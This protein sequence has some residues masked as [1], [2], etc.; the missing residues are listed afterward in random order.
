MFKKLED[1][2]EAT[3]N[4]YWS[5]ENPAILGRGSFGNVQIWFH[6][7]KG[8]L[9]AAKSFKAD[10][11]FRYE[12]E[13]VRDIEHENVIRC[14]GSYENQRVILYNLCTT[15]LKEI[16]EEDTKNHFGVGELMLRFLIKHMVS[17]Q[18]HLVNKLRI[19]H[20]D[21]KPA[22]ILY[23]DR[24]RLFILTDFGLAIR[25]DAEK[26]TYTDCS[27][28]G[29][30]DFM[31]PDLIAKLTVPPSDEQLELSI[32]SEIWSLAVTIFIAATGRH[33]F[34]T[35]IRSKGFEMARD[36]PVGSFW[37]DKN[38]TY[39]YELRGYNRLSSGFQVDVLSPLLVYMMSSD[40]D[41][42][43]L[44]TSVDRR[45]LDRDILFVFDA[46]TFSFRKLPCT[47][48]RDSLTNVLSAA[49]LNRED[50]TL[51]YME[52]FI[53]EGKSVIPRTT[54]DS[55]VIICGKRPASIAN[56]DIKRDTFGSL[57]DFF[58]EARVRFYENDV[59]CI[60]ENVVDVTNFCQ[61]RME[62]VSSFAKTYD[63]GLRKLQAQ[64]TCI[65]SVSR[66]T[67]KSYFVCIDR[68]K[69]LVILFPACDRG[70][71]KHYC[72]SR[73]WNEPAYAKTKT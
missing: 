40:A 21:I 16:L 62:F 27:V 20:R 14:L 30:P 11:D 44:F 31:R 67:A 39:M 50:N 15:T 66:W 46:N 9:C 5:F 13:H 69:S 68:V 72:P 36:K 41:F 35:K 65:A 70:R 63:A 2:P 25:Y 64:L 37:V 42:A 61:L 73:F 51:V 19:I 53:P 3:K 4:L 34:K 43:G 24:T 29:T 17:A 55:P 49:N 71:A 60:F 56:A 28:K 10:A 38:E 45:M 48:G 23:D 57:L 52:A 32:A 26:L 54:E 22:N 12:L 59:R 7:S 58:D 1:Q 47:I 33:P 8:I 18:D 6:H